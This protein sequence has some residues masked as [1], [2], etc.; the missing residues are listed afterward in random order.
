MSVNLS[1]KNVPDELAEQLRRRAAANRRSLQR[2][3][4]N[5]L[6]AAAGHGGP[7]SAVDAPSDRAP[8][9]ALTIEE[10][11]ELSRALFPR[12]TQS[13]VAYIR[14]LRDSR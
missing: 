6:E 8:R 13:S 7:F 5:I 9:D 4:L 14:Q 1:V 3:L 2:E 11:A 10:L 12:G